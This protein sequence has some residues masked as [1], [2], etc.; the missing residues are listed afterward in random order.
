MYTVN[1]L[2][3]DLQTQKMIFEIKSNHCG[4]HGYYS[5]LGCNAMYIGKW[6]TN[7]S[8]QRPEEGG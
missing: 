1:K 6:D 4:D 7:S 3:V 2:D 8:E 5:I